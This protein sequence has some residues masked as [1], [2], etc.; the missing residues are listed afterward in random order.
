MIDDAMKVQDADSMITIDDETDDSNLEVSVEAPTTEE[1]IDDEADDSNLEVSVE[2]PTT[3]EDQ[4]ATSKPKRKF[5]LC[6]EVLPEDVAELSALKKRLLGKLDLRLSL[7]ENVVS[8]TLL[9]PT[10]K[11]LDV[12]PQMKSEDK[13]KH[14]EMLLK[15]SQQSSDST[16]SPVGQC[17]QPDEPTA[18]FSKRQK[19]LLKHS[20]QSNESSDK[21]S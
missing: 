18:F 20:K 13:V 2:A 15:Q 12:L 1:D 19:L 14:L 10:T 8:M 3:E 9:D 7:S 6:N 21:V 4:A 16:Q 11:G 17:H 5:C